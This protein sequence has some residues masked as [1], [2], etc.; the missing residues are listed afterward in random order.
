MKNL[1]VLLLLAGLSA[2]CSKPTGTADNGGDEDKPSKTFWE[3]EDDSQF[4]VEVKPWPPS[5]GKATVEAVASIG[6]W[7]GDLPL[8]E[9]VQYRVVS[10]PKSSQPYKEMKREEKSEGEGEDKI[11]TYHYT[12][13][14]VP[15]AKG[16]SFIQFKAVG[17]GF[18]QT[19]ELLDWSVKY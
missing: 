17:K 10:D 19:A 7:G 14:D 2:G 1:L 13:T 6:D 18:R 3:L 4:D 5:G 12:A 8:V 11:T 15:F 16:T 9:S